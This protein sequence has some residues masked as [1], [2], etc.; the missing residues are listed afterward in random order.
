[1]NKQIA[2]VAG[3]VIGLAFL[4]LVVTRIELAAVRDAFRSADVWLI[5]PFLAALFA[6]YQAK[7]LRW[8]I[9]LSNAAPLGS[10]A[11]FGPLM[12]GYA[13]SAILPM[14]LGEVLKLFVINREHGVR[15]AA[16][17]A[18]VMVERVFDLLTIP[19]LLLAVLVAHE[20]IPSE[21]ANGVKII[22][23][24]GIVLLAGIV[25][26]IAR[27][28]ALHRIVERVPLLP[29]G[30]RAKVIE[31]LDLADTGMSP[32]RQPGTLSLIVLWSLA[33]WLL[34]LLCIF[35]S[36]RAFS[37]DLPLS[38]SVVVL[39]FTILSVT[40][41]TSP[42]YIG[43]IQLAYYLALT[44]YGISASLAFSASLFYHVLAYGAVVVVGSFFAHRHGVRLSR[45]YVS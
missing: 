2:T 17:I 38:A 43:S 26:Y 30:I 36:L 8:S 10:K 22:N 20:S 16:G 25:F 11:L 42:G 3:I 33:Q 27:P 6:Y 13:G 21:L 4:A 9:I 40:L 34:M 31:Q 15:M 12:I 32:L 18:S 24:A 5:A 41:P 39:A 23:I 44:P 1:M 29:Q 7:A 45:R 35:L 19:L 28:T 37:I 14:Q